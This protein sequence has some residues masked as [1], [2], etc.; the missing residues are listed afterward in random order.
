MKEAIQAGLHSLED[1]STIQEWKSIGGGDIN[2]SYYV[3]TEKNEY[4]VK[5]N[6]NVPSHF[7]KAEASGLKRIEETGTISVPHVHYFDEPENDEE[8]VMIL[9]WVPTGQ[10]DVSKQLGHQ[11]AQMHKH[12][13]DA[14]GFHVP[15]FVGEL[16]QP[17]AESDSWLTYYRDDRLRTQ[18]EYGKRNGLISGRRLDQLQELTAKLEQWIPDDPGASLLHGDLWGGNWMAGGDGKPYLIDPSVLYGD[19]AFELAFTELF[20]GFSR[21]FYKAYEEIQPL[22]DDYEVR[23]PLYQLFYLLVH[24]NMFGES[25]GPSVDRIARAYT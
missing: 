25:Y 11:L 10:Q 12:T 21:D 20:G 13:G 4:F 16:D 18:I 2:R 5:G 17:E 9:D 19:F 15:T 24:L 6:Q 1:E 23:K 22:P 7:F 8:A 3:R 14:Y